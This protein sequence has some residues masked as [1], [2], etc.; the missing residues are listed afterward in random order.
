MP[1]RRTPGTKRRRSLTRTMIRKVRQNTEAERTIAEN[2]AAGTALNGGDPFAAIDPNTDDM[3]T[4]TLG[5]P[6]ASSFEVSSAAGGTE[7]QITVGAGTKLDYETKQT[8]TVT[9]IATDS[10]GASASIEVTITVTDENEGPAITGAAEAEYAENGE[11]QVAVFTAVDPE[12]MGAVV[13]SLGGDDADDD[14]DDFEIDKSSGVL[15]FAESPDYEDA[16]GGGSKRHV[17]HL[18]CDGG[19]PP[20]RMGWRVR[21]KSR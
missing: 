5:G 13:W 17:K 20:T 4:Y 12:D 9:V 6:D 8:Y 18:L 3:L 21:R 19:G 7:G 10:F 15:T 2:A 1:W 11:G 16:M 14:A